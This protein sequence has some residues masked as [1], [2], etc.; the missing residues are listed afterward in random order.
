MLRSYVRYHKRSVATEWFAGYG[1]VGQFLV[2]L[3]C[4]TCSGCGTRE[5]RVAT[6]MAKGQVVA[7][8][9]S[10]IPHVLVVLHPVD[11]SLD[12]PKP[13][14]TTDA[15][16]RYQLTTYDTN[17]GAPEGQFAVTVEQWIR[18]NPNLP[19][20]NHLPQSFSKTES[21]GIRILIAKGENALEPIQIR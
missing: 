13:R 14:G 2:G 1:M 19:P 12:S 6:F 16:G 8:D 7:A 11:H 18:D 9:G 21:S 15:E 3:V 5:P 4:L 17:D 10:P 20:S